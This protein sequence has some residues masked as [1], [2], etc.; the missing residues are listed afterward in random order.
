MNLLGIYFD[1]NNF[2]LDLKKIFQ[3]V[4]DLSIRFLSFEYIFFFYREKRGLLT[5]F[6]QETIFIL[7]TN[8]F[9]EEFPI[10]NEEKLF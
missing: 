8:I 5:I 10:K 6:I 3:I 2:S 1:D 9:N 7:F 4:P